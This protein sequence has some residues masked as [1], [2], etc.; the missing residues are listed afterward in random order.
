MMRFKRPQLALGVGLAVL[1]GVGWLG[2]F[3]FLEGD[4]PGI[5]PLTVAYNRILGIPAAVIFLGLLRLWPLVAIALFICSILAGLTRRRIYRQVLVGL[6]LLPMMGIILFPA[7]STCVSGPSLTVEPWGQT[8]RTAYTSA[9]DD[10]TYGTLLLFQCDRTG[11][12]CRAVHHLASDYTVTKA[13]TLAYNAKIDQLSLSY[14]NG[15]TNVIYRRSQQ[16]L[17]CAANHLNSLDTCPR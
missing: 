1:A 6:I 16:K 10:D 8:Y 14:D 5:Y 4:W 9:I 13:L 15:V 12:W 2:H 11:L 17:L 7:I 3:P